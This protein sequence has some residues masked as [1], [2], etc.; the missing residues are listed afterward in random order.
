MI[1]RKTKTKNTSKTAEKPCGQCG[2]PTTTNETCHKCGKVTC[3]NCAKFNEETRYCPACFE[4]IRALY[5][6]A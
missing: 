3:N 5:K 6:L 4:K 2:K 1:N